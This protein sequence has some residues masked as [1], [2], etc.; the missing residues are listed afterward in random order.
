[1]KNIYIPFGGILGQVGCHLFLHY[2]LCEC[3]G[4]ILLCLWIYGALEKWDEVRHHGTYS[5]I[6]NKSSFLFYSCSAVTYPE[7]KKEI[8]LLHLQGNASM[9]LL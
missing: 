2:M 7:P 1:M 9:V 5:L 4:N 3:S 6:L 8:S